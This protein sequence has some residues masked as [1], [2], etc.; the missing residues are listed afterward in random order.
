MAI[1]RPELPVT[2][3]PLFLYGTLRAM[4][5]L[6]WALTGDSRKTDVVAPLIK[7]ALLEGY[8]RF[9]LFGKDYPALI[10]HNETSI[11]DGLLLCPQNKSQRRK[12]D[13]FEGEAYTVTPVQVT[14]VGEEGQ[15]V[16]ADIYLWNGERDAVSA[17]SWDLDTFIKERLD[18]WIELFG[19]MQLV[20][21]DEDA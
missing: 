11:V 4:P 5:L 6:A 1:T 16:E 12:L 2:L 18:D 19:G 20:G 17:D 9:S 10:K 8:A 3:R 13:D 15:M 14:V 7:P 21:D